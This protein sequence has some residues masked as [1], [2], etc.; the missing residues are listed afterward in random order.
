VDRIPGPGPG[1]GLG[2]GALARVRVKRAVDR[3][4]LGRFVMLT[5]RSRL[6]QWRCWAEMSNTKKWLLFKFFFPE[7]IFMYI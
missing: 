4:L 5:E 1:Y 3:I 6:G 7:A 2:A